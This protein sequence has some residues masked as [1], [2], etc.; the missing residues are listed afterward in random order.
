MWFWR[1][2]TAVIALV[3][4]KLGVVVVSGLGI[5]AMNNL[6]F[7]GGLLEALGRLLTGV[8]LVL[9]ASLVPIVAF[10]FFGFLDEQTVRR[11]TAVPSPASSAAAKSS[12][13]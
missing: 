7:D 4:T 10:K 9:I 3:F 11:C 2:V 1:W 8:V 5:S 13:G 6:D 12:G